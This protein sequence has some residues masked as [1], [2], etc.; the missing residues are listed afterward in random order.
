MYSFD[1]IIIHKTNAKTNPSDSL[2]S[3]NKNKLFFKEAR[4]SLI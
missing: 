2:F 1:K 3:K 4:E